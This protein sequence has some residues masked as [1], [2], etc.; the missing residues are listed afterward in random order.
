MS[1][2][3]TSLTLSVGSVNRSLRE[4]SR[5]DDKIG[6]V[7]DVKTGKKRVNLGLNGEV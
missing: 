5:F 3:F 7:L 2:S 1:W 4:G 6:M